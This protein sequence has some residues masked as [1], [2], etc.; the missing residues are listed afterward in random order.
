[1]SLI[2]I[3]YERRRHE[4]SVRLALGVDQRRLALQ[5]L[6][7]LLP[8]V[9]TGWLLA[10]VL[11]SF[12]GKALAQFRLPSGIDLS[13]LDMSPDW[14][15]LLAAFA[16]STFMA[17][18]AGLVPARRLSRHSI[19][20]HLFTGIAQ[21][22]RS[23]GVRRAVVTVNIAVSAMVVATA[24]ATTKAVLFGVGDAPGFDVQQTLFVEVNTKGHY[25]PLDEAQA[26]A[27]AQR[28][29]NASH[30][31]V[32]ALRAIPSVEGVVIGDFPIGAVS[33]T[34]LRSPHSIKSENDSTDVRFWWESTT[35]GYFHTLGIYP[36]I[37]AFGEGDELVVTSSLATMLWPNESPLG[38]RLQSDFGSGTVG[39]VVDLPIASL[40]LG[41]Q[42]A[43]FSFDKESKLLASMKS[44]GTVSFIVRAP[45]PTAIEPAVREAV[46]S[47]FP[48]ASKQSIIPG[49]QLVAEDIGRER[50]TSFFLTVFGVV[51][52]L[53]AIGGVFG[54]VSYVADVSRPS[55]AVRMMLGSSHA[56]VM[57]RT[58]LDAVGPVA[59]GTFVGVLAASLLLRSLESQFFGLSAS[60]LAPYFLT[61]AAFAITAAAAG[62]L[63]SARL[64]TLTPLEVLRPL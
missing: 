52:F 18:V 2:L 23:L 26:T 29:V 44:R 10:V 57:M 28:S 43:V 22:P 35:P 9:L 1:M 42:P 47:M 32:D 6:K 31:L 24:S 15:V 25:Q 49:Y 37:G 39:A 50:L 30:Q 14:R 38:H 56:N 40:R 11:A 33:T 46:N 59:L 21:T 12:A 7:E 20:S 34:A 51:A 8:P 45:R 17:L 41:H 58:I 63:A 48:N 27:W 53:L 3:H 60:Q 64:R 62:A 5:L 19:S 55:L 16:L 13:R 4:F 36:L 54:L 61:S